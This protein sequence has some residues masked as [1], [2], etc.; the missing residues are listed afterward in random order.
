MSSLCSDW[1]FRSSATISPTA[2]ATLRAAQTTA[3]PSTMLMIA[4]SAAMK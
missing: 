2:P 3:P 4:G 1:N